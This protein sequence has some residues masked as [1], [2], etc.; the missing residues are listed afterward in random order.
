MFVLESVFNSSLNWKSIRIYCNLWLMSHTHSS[1]LIAIL[2]FQPM[3]CNIVCTYK[4]LNLFSH[5]W[6]TISAHVNFIYLNTRAQKIDNF[7][8]LVSFWW[9]HSEKQTKSSTNLDLNSLFSVHLLL[10]LF[11]CVCS[12]VY[13]KERV[14]KSFVKR[15]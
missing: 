6:Y 8:L 2:L 4:S 12:V 10:L 3:H 13:C 11:F 7:R 5:Y 15:R 1:H 14:G 9:N